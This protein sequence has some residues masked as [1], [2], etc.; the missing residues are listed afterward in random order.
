[1]WVVCSD[2]HVAVESNGW[3]RSSQFGDGLFE[4]MSVRDRK[5][6]AIDRHITRMQHGLNV[7]GIPLSTPLSD[8]FNKMLNA[9][10]N[11]SQSPQGQLKIIISRGVSKRGYRYDANISPRVIAFYSHSSVL[12]DSYY[13]EGICVK[14]CETESVIH[15]QLAGLKHLNRL[16]SVLAVRELGDQY[17]EGILQ[18]ALGHIV[19]G[20]MSNIFMEVNGKLRT[21]DLNLSGVLGTM[22]Q[23]VLEYCDKNAIPIDQ[24]TVEKKDILSAQGLFMTNRLIGIWPVKSVEETQFSIQP[25]TKKLIQAYKLGELDA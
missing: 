5:I 24:N 18:N 11:A 14:F 21:P 25:I 12:P 8:V 6:I 22:R 10:I 16:D 20:S 1:M 7:L 19:E 2:D 23:A 15:K 17:Q 9:L 13:E 3:D 4:T